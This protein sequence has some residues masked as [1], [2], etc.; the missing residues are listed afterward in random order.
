MC[1]SSMKVTCEAREVRIRTFRSSPE[2][3]SSWLSETMKAV[4]AH[5]LLIACCLAESELTGNRSVFYLLCFWW[6]AGGF[7]PHILLLL[8]SIGRADSTW[9]EWKVY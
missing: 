6:Y 4:F 2:A 9:Q 5:S 1:A 3:S 8:G 7:L